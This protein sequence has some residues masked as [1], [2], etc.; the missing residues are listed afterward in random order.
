MNAAARV[1]LVVLALAAGFGLLGDWLLRAAPVGLGAT[2]WA[3][4][5]VGVAAGLARWR[6][7]LHGSLALG[8]ALAPLFA[9]C[10]AWRDS[11]IL[12]EL[13]VLALVV[14]F[15]LAAAPRASIRRVE[16]D[17]LAHAA[18]LWFGSL[19]TGLIPIV[20]GDIPWRELAHPRRR[21]HVAAL[22]R[23]LALAV[24]LLIVFGILF[25][26][27]DAVFGNALG[28]AVPHVHRPAAQLATVLVWGW[29]AAGLLRVAAAGGVEPPAAD[30]P[31]AVRL[32][33]VEMCVVL[34]LVDLLFAAFVAVQFRAFVGG[35][36]YVQQHARLT[37]ADYARAGFFQLAGV[38]AL[39]LLLLLALDW[40]LRRDERG[41]NAA[42]R[43]LGGVLVA[44]VFAVLLSA[45]HRMQLYERTFGLTG[46]RFYTLAFMAWLAVGFLWL[47]WTVL[48]GHR[49][50][51]AG[52]ILV[53]G[54]LTIL[55][56]NA[57][58]PDAVIARVDVHLVRHGRSV[59]YT[60]LGTL[61]DDAVP[62]LVAAI[63]ELQRRAQAATT[64]GARGP[65]YSGPGSITALLDLQAH[66][67]AD[68][69]T[70]NR[71]RARARELLCGRG[72]P[73][74][75][76]LGGTVPGQV[77]PPADTQPSVWSKAR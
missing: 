33:T 26:T 21:R 47:A 31:R 62:T 16:L 17:E 28:G 23:G 39:A 59:D 76:P 40:V 25:A 34:G 52:G 7:R 65:S 48:R 3:L 58:N 18:L 67:H 6:G 54:L 4:A 9:L 44:L 51:F 64:F 60:Y 12:A 42:F 57:L 24:P 53:S 73:R 69:R 8:L 32:G 50:R 72:V 15:A 19:V 37:Y 46:L 14:C 5:L 68:W 22:G 75:G 56:L 61:S 38:A 20:W 43:L 71:S 63:P 27:A 1:G 36:T 55:A 35:Q 77:D 41:A 70:W 10:L 13:D 29:L 45:V 11:P 2:L 30:R 66:C 49:E 74:T